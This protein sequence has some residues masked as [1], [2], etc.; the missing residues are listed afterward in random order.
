MG[1]RMSSSSSSSPLAATLPPEAP[2]P[3]PP[4]SP[5]GDPAGSCIVVSPS[6]TSSWQDCPTSLEGF[7][8][9]ATPKLEQ[10]PLPFP[11][12]S[13]SSIDSFV[14]THDSSSSASMPE[15]GYR[16]GDA[17]IFSNLAAC[18][19]PPDDFDP[20][21]KVYL[22][23]KLAGC[24]ARSPEVRALV[25]PSSTKLFFVEWPNEVIEIPLDVL[26]LHAVLITLRYKRK[27]RKNINIGHTAAFPI[28]DTRL[29]PEHS[30]YIGVGTVTANV[31]FKDPTTPAATTFAGSN[32][33]FSL[34]SSR[35][36]MSDGGSLPSSRTG[37]ME[38]ICERRPVATLAVPER[39]PR[40]L[41]GDA[42]PEH[43]RPRL[44]K[45]GSPL[46]P[47]I[48]NAWQDDSTD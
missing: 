21:Q 47:I 42:S 38:N 36:T 39:S 14:T 32:S 34:S 22:S 7:G 35:S 11:T 33:S 1:R 16:P 45:P 23:I 46:S 3:P 25:T 31:R 19:R 2:V 6:A 20:A 24:K 26:E 28:K 18:F 9:V 44:R 10:P 40:S 30:F 48:V 29:V 17:L 43:G 4:R 37:S 15:G 13:P 12:V 41:D 5:T 27:F 8:F